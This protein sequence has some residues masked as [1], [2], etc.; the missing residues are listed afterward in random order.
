MKETV[1][2]RIGDNG[3]LVIPNAIRKKLNLKDGDQVQIGVEDGKVVIVPP[4]TLLAEF[5]HLT[6]NLRTTKEDVVQD[7]INERRQEGSRE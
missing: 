3:R 2:T 4:E 1:T 6:S 7:L 5:Y